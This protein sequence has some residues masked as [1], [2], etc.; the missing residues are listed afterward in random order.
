ME[1]AGFL[2]MTPSLPTSLVNKEGQCARITFTMLQ[3]TSSWT[4]R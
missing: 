4:K 2:R 1:K 3:E